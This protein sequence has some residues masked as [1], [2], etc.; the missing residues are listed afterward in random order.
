MEYWAS[1]EEIWEAGE[2]DRQRQVGRLADQQRSGE[3]K[4]ALDPGSDEPDGDRRYSG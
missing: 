3:L 2:R 1:V 4:A